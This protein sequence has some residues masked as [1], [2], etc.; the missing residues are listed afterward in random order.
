MNEFGITAMNSVETVIQFFTYLS[1]GGLA[2]CSV[3]LV[4]A[5]LERTLF[6]VLF[7]RRVRREGAAIGL[8]GGF[9]WVSAVAPLFGIL[10]TVA[11]IMQAFQSGEELEPGT[12]LNGIG[13]SLWTTGLGLLAAIFSV[14][15]RHTFVA[16]T[17]RALLRVEEAAS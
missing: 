5:L 12:L 9:R 10:G 15:L 8:F 1:Y 4:G 2:A 13:T 16:M 3:V 6:W 17:E 14:T 11:G 7:A